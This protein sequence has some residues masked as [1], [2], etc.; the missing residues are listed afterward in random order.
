MKF[1]Q[2]L[3]CA[4]LIPLMAFA[5]I[6]TANDNLSSSLLSIWHKFAVGAVFT[7]TN[8]SEGNEVLM[9]SRHGNGKLQFLDAFATDGVGTSGG[10][11]NQGALALS[12]DNDFLFVVNAGS[13]EI[14]TFS[15]HKHGLKLVDKVPSGGERPISLSVF[16]DRLYVLN[17]GSDSI[18]GFTFD[19]DG[20][21]TPMAE[22][23]RSLSGTETSAAQIQVSPWGDALVVTERATNLIDVFWLDDNGIPGEAVISPSVGT[24]PFGFDF[25][26]RGHLVV[27]E[28]AGGADNASS[29]SS[30]NILETG[31]LEII[32][33]AVP[34]TESAAC[35]L[36]TTPNGR[37]AYTT[38]TR[39]SS[40][41]GFR[42]ERDGSLNLLDLDG[43]TGNTGEG[44]NPL[45]MAMSRNGRHLYA[46]S[47]ATEEIVA[48][49]IRG[50]GSLKNIQSVTAAA[51]RI[52]GLAAY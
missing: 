26:R 3:R 39:S 40:I 44:T 5:S 41:S 36:I 4:A 47:P 27:S 2:L 31:Q 32:S 38:N 10:L 33:G 8:D 16:Q 34:T 48:F 22:A 24:T 9:F 18:N 15:V 1:T 45:D 42:I 11:G 19:H 50:N 52:N 37:F 17:T 49:R 6:T 43:V 29:V 12:K 51:P 14:T 30:Y 35:W 46:I 28:A 25:D 23:I 20:K 13:N 21:L 7:Q